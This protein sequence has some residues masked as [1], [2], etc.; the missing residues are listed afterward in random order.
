MNIVYSFKYVNK[1]N[2]VV[3]LKNIYSICNILY[4]KWN[5]GVKGNIC[6]LFFWR[7]MGINMLWCVFKGF[8]INFVIGL[9]LVFCMLLFW[10]LYNL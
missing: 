10:Y 9:M 1:K 3:C 2:I 4:E 5:K 6:S 8:N 7:D